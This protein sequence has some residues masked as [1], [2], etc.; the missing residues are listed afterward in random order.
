MLGAVTSVFL[1]ARI[2]ETRLAMI[3]LLACFAGAL[4]LRAPILA[5]VIAACSILGAGFS[6]LIIALNIALQRLTPNRLLGRASA[7][8]DGVLEIPQ[9]AGVAFG[10]VASVFLTPQI[11]TWLVAVGPFL[12]F[13]YLLAW[14]FELGRRRRSDLADVTAL[15]D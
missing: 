4:L 2:G 12:G 8:A 7:A 9:L 10:A 13:S 15:D 1:V 5:W 14:F 11:L 6:L 3:G